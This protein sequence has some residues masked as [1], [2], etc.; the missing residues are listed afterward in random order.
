METKSSKRIKCCYCEKIFTLEDLERHESIVHGIDN[1]KL[2]HKSIIEV[3]DLNSETEKNCKKA[4]RSLQFEEDQK[5]SDL[6]SSSK[7]II[8]EAEKSFEAL[9]TSPDFQT[10]D[11]PCEQSTD[12]P[13]ILEKIYNKTETVEKSNDIRCLEVLYGN[14]VY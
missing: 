2:K 10:F 4:V 11:R 13:E 5:S 1:C 3:K 8:S 14:M 9:T 12:I 6:C 7:R